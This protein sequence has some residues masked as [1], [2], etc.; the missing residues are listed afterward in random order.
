MRNIKRTILIIPMIII[1]TL[2]VSGCGGGN[3]SSLISQSSTDVPALVQESLEQQ[4]EK[5]IDPATADE[6]FE[7]LAEGLEEVPEDAFIDESEEGRQ[8]AKVALHNARQ[9]Q[10]QKNYMQAAKTLRK[11]TV[12]RMNECSCKK[13]KKHQF[14]SRE[15]WRL[16][17]VKLFFL[18]KY[19]LHEGFEKIE[20]IAEVTD[21]EPGETTILTA[22]LYYNDG[23]SEDVTEYVTWELTNEEAGVIEE[24]VFTAATDGNTQVSA[25]LF[26]WLASEYIL[27][28][29]KT[30]VVE[31]PAVEKF[32]CSEVLS[33]KAPTGWSTYPDTIVAMENVPG[34]VT[35]WGSAVGYILFNP[36]SSAS[37]LRVLTHPPATGCLLAEGNPLQ[38]LTEAD[39]KITNE[40]KTITVYFPDMSDRADNNRMA[41]YIGADGSTYWARS[42]NYLEERTD[43]APDL[44][45]EQAVVPGHLARQA[46]T[47]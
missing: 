42:D 39:I 47:D 34:D 8:T 6:I 13:N 9:Y 15:D 10:K 31:P 4:Q 35:T 40:E 23:F 28:T 19:I 29:V 30:A 22:M 17:R 26:G 11:G 33:M 37:F 44:T 3:G 21:L 25:D 24:N 16:L 2:I 45:Y 1:I 27:I 7:Q 14:C 46:P 32:T 12:D 18:V 41:V 20:T 38:D 5:N 36:D 43:Y